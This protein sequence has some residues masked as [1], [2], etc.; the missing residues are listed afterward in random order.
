[1]GATVYEDQGT[2]LSRSSSRRPST[3]MLS[4]RSTYTPSD[5]CSTGASSLKMRS[6]HDDRTMFPLES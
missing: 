5:T 3:A 1:M 6:T 4:P 2:A